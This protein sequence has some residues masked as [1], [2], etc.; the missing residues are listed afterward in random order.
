MR[1]VV[2]VSFYGDDPQCDSDAAAEALR[3]AGYEIHRL[4]PE[5]R[6]FFRPVDDHV[7][8]I[9]EG[10]PGPPRWGVSGDVPPALFKLMCAIM[11]EIDDLVRHYGGLCMECD[12]V[13]RDYIPFSLELGP[14][15]GNG[16]EPKHRA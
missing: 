15:R 10:P 5:R 9:T 7:E 2:Q 4:P 16:R 8:A 14:P 6:Q 3:K 13:D 12:Q 1:L 11:N